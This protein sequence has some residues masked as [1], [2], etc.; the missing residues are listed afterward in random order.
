MLQYSEIC[1]L[2]RLA[3][4]YT[5]KAIAARI[6]IQLRQL[7]YFTEKGTINGVAIRSN[8]L[9]VKFRRHSEKYQLLETHDF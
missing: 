4:P 3:S 5:E 2:S 6:K 1:I 7:R 8:L 9:S